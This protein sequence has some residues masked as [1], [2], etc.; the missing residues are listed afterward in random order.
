MKVLGQLA[1]IE[2]EG[3]NEVGIVLVCYLL[4]QFFTFHLHFGHRG[5]ALSTSIVAVINFA[6]LYHMMA[7]HIDGL[8]T[9]AMLK[10]IGKL[11]LA[12]VPLAL[13][14]MAAQHWLFAGL[15]HMA[16]LSKL[17][18]VFGSIGAA[19]AVFGLTVAFLGIEEVE[20]VVAMV[21]RKLGRRSAG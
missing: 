19:A 14:C 10:N 15:A 9:R 12:S 4:N 5:L 16:F 11:I 17:I 21:K 1:C 18:A 20:D 7:R 13:V 6:I 8:E 3:V 2:K